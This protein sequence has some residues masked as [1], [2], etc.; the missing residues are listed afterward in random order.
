MFM[1]QACNSTQATSPLHSPGSINMDSIT[2]EDVKAITFPILS[3]IPR[4]VQGLSDMIATSIGDA[5]GRQGQSVQLKFLMTGLLNGISSHI[6]AIRMCPPMTNKNWDIYEPILALGISFTWNSFHPFS[7]CVCMCLSLSLFV[8]LCMWGVVFFANF[9]YKYIL[10]MTICTHLLL[11]IT[12][13]THV[14]T[15]LSI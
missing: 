11:K 10:M 6:T 4:P 5:G 7:L 9:K 13:P 15:Q 14:L 8:C 3:N 12:L 1:I 2:S